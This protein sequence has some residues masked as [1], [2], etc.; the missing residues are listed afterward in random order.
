MALHHR[1]KGRKKKPRTEPHPIPYTH[2]SIAIKI[3]T[4]LTKLK[5]VEKAKGEAPDKQ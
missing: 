4:T 2:K 5:Q 3:P 1:E